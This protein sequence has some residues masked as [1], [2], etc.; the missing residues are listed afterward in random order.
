MSKGLLQRLA[1]ASALFT[2]GVLLFSLASGIPRRY[3][4]VAATPMTIADEAPPTLLPTVVVRA[5]AI[6]PTLPTI[7]VR[8]PRLDHERNLAS[9]SDHAHAT[10]AGGAS[11]CSS[12]MARCAGLEMPYYSFGK[13]LRSFRE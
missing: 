7:T 3:S 4:H 13:T 5:D 8:A 9:A 12:S 6:I 11:D 10:R 1:L 2:T